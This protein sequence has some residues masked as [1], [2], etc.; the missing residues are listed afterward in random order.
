M[1]A[2]DSLLKNT[3]TT[4]RIVKAA[5]KNGFKVFSYQ[6]QH[7]L[8]DTTKGVQARGCYLVLDAQGDVQSQNDSF[9]LEL[10]TSDIILIRQNP[11]YDLSYH[12]S[13]GILMQLPKKNIVQN[14]PIALRC[15]DEKTL[16]FYFPSL[17]PETSI[18]S[19][20]ISVNQF[21]DI[22]RTIIVKPLYSYGGH[23][24]FKLTHD[25]VNREAL[26]EIM[27]QKHHE[28]LVIQAFCSD[29]DS[30]ERRLFFVVGN[31]ICGF[32]LVVSI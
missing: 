8:L 16:P 14:P 20:A 28:G 30:T 1:N 4:I 25:D 2:L 23:D 27:C 29:V 24:V 18:T 9:E 31:L 15:F 22:Y 6:P 3:D 17:I 7:L 26:I 5:L 19:D 12:T 32:K 11:P 10:H 13:L 21:L